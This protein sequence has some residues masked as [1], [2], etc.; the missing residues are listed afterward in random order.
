MKIIKNSKVYLDTNFLVAYL[1]PAK[2]EKDK[3]Y[4]KKDRL[5]LIKNRLKM[6]LK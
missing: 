3:I 2:R 5:K 6:F 1:I 4:N